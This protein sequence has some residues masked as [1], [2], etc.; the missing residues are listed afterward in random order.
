M[1][2]RRLLNGGRR[3]LRFTVG[4]HDR[5][6]HAATHVAKHPIER[7]VGFPPVNLAAQPLAEEKI[8]PSLANAHDRGSGS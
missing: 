2:S 7:M 8:A 6:H 1:R 5:K 4:R 3:P